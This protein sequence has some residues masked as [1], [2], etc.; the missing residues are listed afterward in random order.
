MDKVFITIN[1]VQY[2]SIEAKNASGKCEGCVFYEKCVNE[3]CHCGFLG[4]VM[5]GKHFII[6]NKQ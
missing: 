5:D 3:E 6:S 2:E 1:G 4:K